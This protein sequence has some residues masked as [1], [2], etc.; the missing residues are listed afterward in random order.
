MKYDLIFK[1]SQF[2]GF[3]LI[4]YSLLTDGKFDVTVSKYFR[5]MAVAEYL[6][7]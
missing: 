2:N 7:I 5:I 3:S 4:Y 6:N 1:I